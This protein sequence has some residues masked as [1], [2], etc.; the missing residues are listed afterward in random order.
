MSP[1]T[2]YAVARADRALVEWRQ[3]Q[4]RLTDKRFRVP[5]TYIFPYCYYYECQEII[6]RSLDCSIQWLPKFHF[7]PGNP[8]PVYEMYF[9]FNAMCEYCK[10]NV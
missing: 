5:K 3:I 1:I 8:H 4:T 10:N 9:N 7:T 6:F 2:V